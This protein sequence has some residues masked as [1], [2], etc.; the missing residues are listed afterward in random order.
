MNLLFPT[1]KPSVGNL[2]FSR[3]FSAS[4]WL[5]ILVQCIV[6]HAYTQCNHTLD[7]QSSC[8]FNN[9]LITDDTTSWDQCAGTLI[10]GTK[11]P[12][13]IIVKTLII[14]KLMK[15]IIQVIQPSLLTP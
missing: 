6:A 15:R 7:C 12:T 9:L 11:L 5:S 3:D 4:C 8:T 13:V 2:Y 1:R 14:I 10:L